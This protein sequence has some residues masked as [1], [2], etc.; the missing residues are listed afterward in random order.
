MTLNL[1]EKWLMRWARR[2][3]TDPYFPITNGNGIGNGNGN[4]NDKISK[5]NQLKLVLNH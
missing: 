4:G 3:L 2:T 1:S 5:V